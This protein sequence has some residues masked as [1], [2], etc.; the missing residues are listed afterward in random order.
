M[1]MTY[2]KRSIIDSVW[3]SFFDKHCLIG[4][5]IFFKTGIFRRYCLYVSPGSNSK[6]MGGRAGAMAGWRGAMA[7]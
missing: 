7:G 4:S 5:Q 6:E 1:L 3:Q 2:C